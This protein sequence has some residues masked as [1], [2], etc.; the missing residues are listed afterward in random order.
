MLSV[1]IVI[2]YVV[3]VLVLM[4][5]VLATLLNLPGTVLILADAVI[6]SAFTHWQRPSLWTLGG[7][8]I[9]A[10]VA[11]TSDN[12]LSMVATQRGGGSGRAG[13]AAMVGGIGGALLGAW[14]S[15]LFGAIGLLGGLVGFLVGGI[16]V[17]LGLALIGGYLA[18]YWYERRQ[19][20]SHEEARQAGKGALIGRLIGGL[21]KGI[22]AILMVAITLYAVF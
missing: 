12:I 1:L 10:I 4:A 21:A 16:I 19:G 14:L 22:I 13:V 15:P 5:G 6:F 20:K 18:A 8:L 11:E 17:P 9:L 7:L 2:G 3:F